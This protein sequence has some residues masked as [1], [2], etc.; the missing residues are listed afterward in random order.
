MKELF[1]DFSAVEDITEVELQEAVA[2]S[3]GW[4][5]TLTDDYRNSLII[6]C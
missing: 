3:D 1:V 6:C 5:T 2:S 4:I